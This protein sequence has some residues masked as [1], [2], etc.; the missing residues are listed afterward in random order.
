MIVGFDAAGVGAGDVEEGGDI[1]Q[2]APGQ[3]I[4][5]DAVLDARDDVV[6]EL[7]VEQRDGDNSAVGQIV[8]EGEIEILPGGR[9]QVRIA[10]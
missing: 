6:A 9:P 8:L 7:L 1:G 2:L 5:G 4:G 10:A 3:R